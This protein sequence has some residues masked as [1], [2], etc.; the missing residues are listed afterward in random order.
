MG[1]VGPLK[2]TPWL[3]IHSSLDIR[4]SSGE[5]RPDGYPEIHGFCAPYTTSDQEKARDTGNARTK[6]HVQLLCLNHKLAESWDIG[7]FHGRKT[8]PTV[9]AMWSLPRPYL[10]KIR[11]THLGIEPKSKNNIQKWC[12]PPLNQVTI[13]MITPLT[14]IIFIT[15]KHN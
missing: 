1:Q 12:V 10:L 4:A 15:H 2:Y 6:T 11:Q 3:Q 9:V 5:L 13:N 7:H 14:T 8:T